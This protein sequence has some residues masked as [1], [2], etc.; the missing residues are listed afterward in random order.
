MGA[1]FLESDISSA[2]LE[3]VPT[4][5]DPYFFAQAIQLLAHQA[6]IDPKDKTDLANLRL[7]GQG[8]Y[9][10]LEELAFHNKL[11]KNELQNILKHN[12]TLDHPTIIKA[13]KSIY[14][15]KRLSAD[16]TNDILKC[17]DTKSG[18]TAVEEIAALIRNDKE[19][20]QQTASALQM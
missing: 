5:R 13:F 19:A 11:N 1:K 4:S 9:C 16:E 20:A 6:L 8:T 18:G 3:L 14:F 2:Y 7:C 15:T 12:A 10:F 17:L